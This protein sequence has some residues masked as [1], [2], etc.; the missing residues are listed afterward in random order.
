MGLT[1]I[2]GAA[3]YVYFNFLSVPLAHLLKAR[4]TLCTLL[5]FTCFMCPKFAPFANLMSGLK[6]QC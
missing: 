2:A 3:V 6:C 4:C 1:I 5:A